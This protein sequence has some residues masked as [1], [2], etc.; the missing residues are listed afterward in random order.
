MDPLDVIS[1][2]YAW[3]NEENG[4]YGHSIHVLVNYLD[5]FKERRFRHILD[6]SPP[7]ETRISSD[8]L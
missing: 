3:E 6:W 2:L 8:T 7:M 1:M 4:R 5:D